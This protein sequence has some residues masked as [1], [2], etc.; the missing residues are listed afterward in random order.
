MM[1]EVCSE[2]DNELQ[3]DEDPPYTYRLDGGR[4]L[5]TYVTSQR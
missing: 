5:K 3:G 2:A 1:G 4:D